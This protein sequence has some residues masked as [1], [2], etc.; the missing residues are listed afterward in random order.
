MAPNL[1]L[2]YFDIDGGRGEAARLAMHIG[3][4]EWEDHRISFEEF[5][6]TR[7]SFPFGRVPGRAISTTCRRTCQRS[8]HRC[9]L[10]WPI[11]SSNEF[12]TTTPNGF[13]A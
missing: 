7:E 12:R 8:A 1:N 3:G 2:T 10:R 6:K 5:G 4:V 11:G 13:E 9:W